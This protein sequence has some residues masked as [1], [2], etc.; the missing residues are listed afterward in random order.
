MD[1]RDLDAEQHRLLAALEDI[2]MSSEL[3]EQL[4]AV[5]REW[6]E[7]QRAVDR[8]WDLHTHPKDPE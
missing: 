8:L 3:R 1:E 5:L 7:K 2:D 6:L 4:E